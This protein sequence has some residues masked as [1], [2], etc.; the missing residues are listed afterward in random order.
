MCVCVCVFE[1]NVRNISMS[2]AVNSPKRNISK[3]FI[4]GDRREPDVFEMN[5]THVYFYE[6][7][8]L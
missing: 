1:L 5:S 7:V 8:I 4:Q 2:E 6:T 3:T